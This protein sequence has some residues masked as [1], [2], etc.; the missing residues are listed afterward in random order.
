MNAIITFILE[1]RVSQKLAKPRGVGKGHKT[2]GMEGGGENRSKLCN[3]G[4]RVSMLALILE[5]QMHLTG[6]TCWSKFKP[7]ALSL[8]GIFWDL[9]GV[10]VVKEG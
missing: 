1:I 7:R 4:G 10:G 6:C 5:Y 9:N 8:K 2:T 3:L